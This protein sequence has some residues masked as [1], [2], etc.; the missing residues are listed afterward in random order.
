M[1]NT[2]HDPVDHARTTRQRA[3]ET[4]KNTRSMPGLVLG[5]LGV[6]ALV[7]CLYLFGRGQQVGGIVAAVG[8]VVL[9][10]AGALWVLAQHRQVS[11]AESHWAAEHP[12]AHTEPPT[13]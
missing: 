8:A 4:L 13:A 9:G 2:G 6:V 3:G 5:A 11:R 10:L 1:G 7:V 12:E